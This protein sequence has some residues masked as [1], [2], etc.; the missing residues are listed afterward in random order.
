MK[1]YTFLTKANPPGMSGVCAVMLAIP[2]IPL[3]A[4]LL[5]GPSNTSS[6]TNEVAV[7]LNSLYLGEF[8]QH[9]H[10]F[11]LRVLGVFTR[12]VIQVFLRER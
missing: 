6:V 9:W 3:L 10:Y 8:G 7:L 5:P 1:K 4:G 12:E 11:I 2:F